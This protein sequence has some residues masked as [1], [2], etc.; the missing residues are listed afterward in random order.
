MLTDGLYICININ[1]RE[2]VYHHRNFC[3]QTK[4]TNASIVIC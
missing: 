2:E 4:N 3:N 1:M